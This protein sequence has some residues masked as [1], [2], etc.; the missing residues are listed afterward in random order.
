MKE[1]MILLRSDIEKDEAQIAQLYAKLASYTT[2]PEA[3]EEAIV[4]GYYLHNLYTA[5]EHLCTL[6][7]AAF[8]N[9]IDDRTQ[10]HSLLLR[11][12]TQDI[13]GC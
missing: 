13:P 7:A 2:A 6:V 11:R 1:K 4:A 10:W 9:Q 3:A 5:F 8:E 12:M